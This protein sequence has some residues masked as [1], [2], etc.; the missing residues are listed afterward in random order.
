MTAPQELVEV[1]LGA[2]TG[3]GCVVVVEDRSAVDLR[4]AGNA[5]ADEDDAFVE[6]ITDA[7]TTAVPIAGLASADRRAVVAEFARM[8]RGGGP[9]PISG[10][11]NIKTIAAVI[12][13]VQSMDARPR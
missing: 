7:G 2:A 9:S 13:A 11:E 6:L 8:V 12:Q 4:W 3:D 10:A 1:A 5:T